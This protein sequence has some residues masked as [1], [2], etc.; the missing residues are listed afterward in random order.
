MKQ[1]IKVCSIAILFS[2][3]LTACST[4]TSAYESVSTTVS[5][6]FKSDDTKK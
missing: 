1:M 6:A 4:I 3:S 5:E 2:L